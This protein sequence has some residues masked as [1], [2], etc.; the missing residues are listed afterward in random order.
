MSPLAN[1]LE[2]AIETALASGEILLQAQHQLS[3][4]RSKSCDNDLVTEADIASEKQILGRLQ[5]ALPEHRFLAEE[6]GEHAAN[7]DYVWAID[8][9][10]GTVNY[11][12]Q[13]PFFCV[14]IG[15]LHRGRPVLGVVHA[16]ALRETYTALVGQGAFLNQQPMQVSRAETIRQSLLATGFPYRRAEMVDNNYKEFFHFA[17]L[18]QDIRRPGAAA[19]DLA[20]VA[21][22]RFEGF[23]DHNLHPWDVVAGA[24][25][26]LEAGGRVSDYGGAPFDGLSGRIVASNAFIHDEMLTELKAVRGS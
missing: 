14:S 26:V 19:L 25:L 17:N 23:W 13:T 7:S 2:L 12:H 10:D 11:A 16:P 4:I 9:L 1:W 5:A 20:Y 8:P 24:A 22:G 3:Q 6:S 21:S 18:C 15:L